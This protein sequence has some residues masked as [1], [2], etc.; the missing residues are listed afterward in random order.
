MTLYGMSQAPT[1]Y[2]DM[3]RSLYTNNQGRIFPI[4]SWLDKDGLATL[5]RDEA[6]SAV[7][8]DANGLVVLAMKDFG[9][10]PESR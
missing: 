4:V 5:V 6:Y 10:G 9:Y 7:V 3:S 8:E 1:E 2:M